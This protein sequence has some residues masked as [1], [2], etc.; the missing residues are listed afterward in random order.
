M[1]KYSYMIDFSKQHKDFYNN[2]NIG[3]YRSSVDGKLLAVNPA[4][5][6]I[7]GL[8][9][10][11]EV[12]RHNITEIYRSPEKRDA[13]VSAIKKEGR[14]NLHSFPA[15]NFKGKNIFVDVSVVLAKD[16]AG[17]IYFDGVVQDVTELEEAKLKL[18]ESEKKFKE[19][20]ENIDIAVF[21][22]TPGASGDFIEVNSAA[23]K[24]LEADTK[25]N[26]LRHKPVELYASPE[27]RKLLSDKI[28]LNGRVK[29]TELR[30]KTLKGRDI[31]VL[32]SIVV[33]KD[34]SG[35]DYFC[36]SFFDITE[37][38]KTESDLFNKLDE[39]ERIN[40]LMVDREL[41]M[42]ELKEEL[43]KLKTELGKK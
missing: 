11:E 28:L 2:I 35:K 1:L 17:R 23:V 10:E 42:I 32:S 18:A 37:R 12:L 33:K 3:F 4:L 29:D 14:I 41:K 15:K 7:S 16:R 6:K 34:D 8:D 43:R 19:L 9:S 31:V 27:E 39:L 21:E 26:L 36:G 24:I 38:K 25:E 20:V 22:S 5:V 40:K 13:I 30:I